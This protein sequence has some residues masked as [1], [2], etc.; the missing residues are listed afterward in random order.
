MDRLPTAQESV[1]ARQAVKQLQ[2]SVTAIRGQ[3][4]AEKARIAELQALHEA[5]INSLEDQRD[6]LEAKISKAQAYLAPV[7]KL[8]DELLSEV[9]VI[10]WCAGDKK[11]GWKLASVCRLWRRV[12]LSLPKI[13]SAIHLKTT[14]AACPAEI[15]R[16]WLERS[17]RTVPLDIDITLVSS[18][19]DTPFYGR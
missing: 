7:R 5:T 15:I 8:P 19:G 10:I 9:F 14:T 3:V 18:W 11:C 16:L 1:L 12:A 17:G 2:S 13:W 4:S 6:E